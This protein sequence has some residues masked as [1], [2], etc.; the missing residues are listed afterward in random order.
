MINNLNS[1]YYINI[2]VFLNIFALVSCSC[3]LLQNVPPFWYKYSDDI[4]G[5]VLEIVLLGKV[6]NNHK[7]IN[8]VILICC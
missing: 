2:I 3:I 7:V 4:F 6:L 5:E 1:Y 8:C